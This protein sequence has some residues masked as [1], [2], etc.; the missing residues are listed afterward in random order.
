MNNIL[1]ATAVA[2]IS[3]FA[4]SSPAFA[5]RVVR[6]FSAPTLDQMHCEYFGATWEQVEEQGL[7]VIGTAG[8]GYQY[9]CPYT[10]LIVR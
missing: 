5:G 10:D 3:A 1:R 7:D 8:T 2:A 4:L 9:G 6:V